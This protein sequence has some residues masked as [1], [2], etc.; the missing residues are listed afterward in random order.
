VQ[1]LLNCIP[2]SVASNLPKATPNI[3]PNL[4]LTDAIFC[5]HTG[6]LLFKPPLKKVEN[7]YEL[8]NYHTLYLA[9]RDKLRDVLSGNVPIQWGKKFIGYEE[10]KE[11]VWVFFEDGT[12]EFCDILIGSDGVNSPGKFNILYIYMFFSMLYS[13]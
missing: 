3:I 2:S 1:S 8:A 12:R 4:E 5:D 13:D 11:G 6:N 10:T 9:Y 7:I